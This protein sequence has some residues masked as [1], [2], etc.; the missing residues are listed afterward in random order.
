MATPNTAGTIHQIVSLKL[1]ASL[2][3]YV[4]ARN[5]GLVIQAPFPVILSKETVVHPDILFIKRGRIGLIRQK[6]LHGTPDLIIE[7]VSPYSPP[8]DQALKRSL[9]S[10]FGVEEYW[11]VDPHTQSIEVLIWSE[12]GYASGGIY[13]NS[14]CPQS[15][16]LPGF[17]IPAHTIFPVQGIQMWEACG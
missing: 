8:H 14:S 2:L 1:A 16:A 15:P 11:I 10:R 17:H 6:S 7:I 13:R 12:L 9:Y 4:E 5:L 3:L